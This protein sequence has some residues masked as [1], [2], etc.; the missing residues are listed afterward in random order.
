[1]W[2]LKLLNGPEQGL[3]IKIGKGLL[4]LGKGKEVSLRFEADKKLS[5]NDFLML[6]DV[7]GRLFLKPSQ[8]DLAF[9]IGRSGKIPLPASWKEL[10]S[11]TLILFGQH[12]FQIEPAKCHD[13]EF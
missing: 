12:L 11:T 5:E 3:K 8:A 10:S 6:Y 2:S 9:I 7:G 4:S 1:M 13:P